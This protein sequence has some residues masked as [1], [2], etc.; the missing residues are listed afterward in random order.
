MEQEHKTL[1][2]CTHV[3]KQ[4]G[5]FTLSD[6]DFTLEPGYILGVIGRNGAGK[7]TLLRTLLGSYRITPSDENDIRLNGIS[8]TK[9]MF[10]YKEQIAYVLHDTPFPQWMN[11]KD[12]GRHYGKY[13][14]SFSGIEYKNL[15]KMFEVPEK[16]ALKN[17]SKGQQIKQQLAFALSYDAKLYV[18]DEPTGNLDIEF[19][20]TFYQYIRSLTAKGDKG[21]IFVSHLV[22]ELERLAD[23]ILWLGVKEEKDSGKKGIQKYFGTMEEL[24]EHFQM[25]DANR[26]EAVEIAPDTIVGVRERENHQEM[27]VQIRRER[28]S[29]SLKRKSRYATLKE[30][31]YYIE[32]GEKEHETGFLG[33][34]D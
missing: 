27:L 7:S 28:L 12:C 25:V 34:L 2:Q 24:R 8:I 17:L 21:V 20:E 31:M 33:N 16:I 6:I 5:E 13:Y 1:L 9:D 22:G 11:A 10:H 29:E 23:Y 32:K 4:K 30:I 15:L 3:T 26:E 18:L 14:Q 19:R